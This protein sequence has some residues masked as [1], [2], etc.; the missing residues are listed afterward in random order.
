M[1]RLVF[2]VTYN[3]AG[4]I[5][6]LIAAVRA[7]GFD[8]LVVD[9]KGADDTAQVVRSYAADDPRVHLIAR[10]GKLGYASASR[11]GLQW[12]LDRDYDYVAQ[13]DADGSHAPQL[14]PAM[15]R[16]LDEVDL[17]IGSRYVFG[18][19]M[20]GFSPWRRVISRLAGSYLRWLLRLPVLDP[21]S[22]FRAWRT[23]FV[24]RILPQSQVAA[25]FAFLYEMLFHAVRDDGRIR[26]IP[27]IF[28]N[29]RAGESKMSWSIVRDAL[30]VVRRL[31]SE[32]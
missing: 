6:P 16:A 13:L 28:E 5:G 20:P 8:V 25:G 10:A 29:R 12:A 15:F 21:T 11:E 24:T 17:V 32:T 2:T 23:D 1:T 19:R 22:G 18:G 14:L 26:E 4:N 3:E 9:D 7:Q 27:I 31:R 30:R